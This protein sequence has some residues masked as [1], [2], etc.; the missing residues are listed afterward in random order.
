MPRC[1]WLLVIVSAGTPLLT[2]QIGATAQ[3]SGDV[4]AAYGAADP[5]RPISRHFGDGTIARLSSFGSIRAANP[6]RQIQ[7]AVRIKF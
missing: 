5:I 7:L 4:A 2:A 6:P 3:L 1:L